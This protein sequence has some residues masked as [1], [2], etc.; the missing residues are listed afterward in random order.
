MTNNL[1]VCSEA[2]YD[3]IVS[4]TDSE[5]PVEVM[6][7][8]Q[9]LLSHIQKSDSSKMDFI[10]LVDKLIDYENV[11]IIPRSENEGFNLTLF[12]SEMGTKVIVAVTHQSRYIPIYKMLG[13][14]IV[15]TTSQGDA[16]YSW[17]HHIT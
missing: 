2:F 3:A 4:L 1:I 16:A 5:S 10:N 15:V 6:S 9:S 7:Y 8:E 13:A 17:L 11:Y 12:F 14:K